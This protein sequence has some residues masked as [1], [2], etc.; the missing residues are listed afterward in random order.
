MPLPIIEFKYL[1]NVHSPFSGLPAESD[2]GPNEADPTLL[3]IYYGSISDYAFLGH[4]INND[5]AEQVED[6]EPV[7]LAEALRIEG[8]LVFVVDTGWNGVNY[9]G[10]APAGS[11][12]LSAPTQ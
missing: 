4:R 9:Y 3:F 11:D 5:L 1:G 7:D 6:L 10:F 8:G 2:D 12:T